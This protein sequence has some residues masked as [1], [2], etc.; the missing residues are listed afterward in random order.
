MD[1]KETYFMGVKVNELD[2][3]GQCECVGCRLKRGWNRSW[4]RGM[5]ERNELILC[6]DCLKEL[7]EKGVIK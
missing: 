1:R 2:G 4:T 5:Y 7:V 6:Y 3:N